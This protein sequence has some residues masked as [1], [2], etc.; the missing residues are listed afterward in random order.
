MDT[1]TGEEFRINSRRIF[2]DEI[3]AKKEA[4]RLN[5][6]K[7]GDEEYCES[8][9]YYPCYDKKKKCYKPMCCRLLRMYQEHAYIMNYKKKEPRSINVG[10]LK[11]H[12]GEVDRFCKILNHRK[13]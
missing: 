5:L 6:L 2:R 12:L 9:R 13:K 1:L 11:M 8:V 3:K 10:A 7:S 4:V